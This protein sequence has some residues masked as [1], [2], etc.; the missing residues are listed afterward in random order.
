[1]RVMLLML[2]WSHANLT[3]IPWDILK[4]GSDV[5]RKDDFPH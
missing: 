2:M 4:R 5:D 1:M 3:T